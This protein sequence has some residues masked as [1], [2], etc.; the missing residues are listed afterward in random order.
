MIHRQPGFLAEV[1]FSMSLRPFWTKLQIGDL[2]HSKVKLLGPIKYRPLLPILNLIA[3]WDRFVSIKIRS[4]EYFYKDWLSSEAVTKVVHFENL[5][6]TLQWNLLNILDF[7]K[8][9]PDPGRITCLEKHTEGYFKRKNRENSGKKHQPKDP[10]TN[11]QKRKIR[12]AIKRINLELQKNGKESL[13]L[14]KYEFYWETVI[15]N[16]E[17]FTLK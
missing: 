7:L 8:L 1:F 16:I 11:E 4:W 2:D 13:P 5:K 15:W 10:F 6:D 3:G 12:A 14:H 9:E 17:L